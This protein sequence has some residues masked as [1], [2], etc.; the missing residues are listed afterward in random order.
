MTSVGKE[1]WAIVVSGLTK[2]YGEVV[3]VDEVSFKVP[4]GEIFALLGP[5]GAGKTTTIRM[6]VGLSCPTAGDAQV[7]GFGIGA[8]LVRLK[9]TVGV[10]PET[11][12]LY[13]ELTLLQNLIFMA[14]LYGVPRGE[15]RGRAERLLAE[16]GLL[17]M[18]ETIFR[19][20]SRGFKRRL[21][22]AAALIHSPQ[23]LFLDEPTLGLDVMAARNLREMIR[24]LNRDGTTVFLTTH[25]IPE[26]EALANR[27]GIIVKGRLIAL[28]SPEALRLKAQAA[29]IIELN[30]ERLPE[31]VIED[32]SALPF[33]SQ[34][35]K[36]GDSRL[37]VVLEEVTSPAREA[38]AGPAGIYEVI[39]LAQSKGLRIRS[40][41]TIRPTLED[42][43]VQLTGVEAEVMRMDKVSSPGARP[44]SSGGGD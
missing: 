14:E 43:F 32:F 27:V 40:L 1:E 15:R 13:E 24:E 19:N 44:G 26:A 7:A 17:D 9:E 33:V 25:N 41:S 8:D 20:L 16:F 10:V 34:A 30:L 12:N 2:H 35:Y 38:P 18:R 21:T 42:A 39:Q 23:V 22:I 3:A 11:S 5:N 36:E 29:T 4:Q 28:E 37:R 31:P 6:L